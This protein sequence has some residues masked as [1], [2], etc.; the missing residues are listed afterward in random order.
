MRLE[1]I[2]AVLRESIP[3]LRM[4]VTVHEPNV[5]L[6]DF[7]KAVSGVRAIATTGLFRGLVGELLAIEPIVHAAGDLIVV[8]RDTYNAFDGKL[9]ELRSRATIVL[10]ALDEHIGETPPNCFAIRLPDARDL[11]SN[12]RLI[13]DVNKILEQIVVNTYVDGQVTLDH[14]ESGSTW[15]VVCVGSH[16]AFGLVAGLLRLYFECKEKA[17]QQRA[18][19]LV[20]DSMRLDANM[21]ATLQGVLVDEVEDYRRARMK[22]ALDEAQIPATDHEQV[23]RLE[24]AVRALGP[25]LERGLEVHPVLSAPSEQRALVPDPKRLEEAIKLLAPTAGIRDPPTGA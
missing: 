9:G 3:R 12:G 8:A 10:E 5:R 21:R 22:Q 6:S 18:R 14:V 1:S 19:E 17:T 4:N 11:E 13:L 7:Q 15:L 24:T 25:L 23:L 16:T 2:R 20:L